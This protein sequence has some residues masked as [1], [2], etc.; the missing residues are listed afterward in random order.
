MTSADATQNPGRAVHP[1]WLPVAKI[2]GD[3]DWVGYTGGDGS[4]GE[5]LTCLL[6]HRAAP[7]IG[8]PQLTHR[9]RISVSFPEPFAPQG[10]T[11]AQWKQID[12]VINSAER[13]IVQRKLGLLV[14]MVVQPQR[15]EVLFYCHDPTQTLAALEAARDRAAAGLTVHA[16]VLEDPRWDA[17]H[18]IWAKHGVPD[19]V[20]GP[21]APPIVKELPPRHPAM[22]SEDAL[23]KWVRHHPPRC[24]AGLRLTWI[25]RPEPI[26]RMTVGFR[27]AHKT[28]GEVGRVHAHRLAETTPTSDAPVDGHGSLVSPI[29][30]TWKKGSEPEQIFDAAADGYQGEFK[31]SSQP[32]G[33]GVGPPVTCAKCGR[34]WF[35][36]AA[37]FGYHDA[38]FDL[39]RDQ[40][41]VEIQNYYA[42][43]RFQCTCTGCGEVI[44][45]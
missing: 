40:P 36:V 22:A 3:S 18:T 35:R 37:L 44:E 30:V 29:H 21:A 16:S 34:E 19:V 25:M 10:P 6:H 39:G 26:S 24:I 31:W 8:H 28:A 5:P 32:R 27:L 23:K 4:A 14:L 7:I 2:A 45:I 15:C 11:D 13:R 12:Q 1:D 42:I 43:A 41:G 20:V 38:A 17:F 33:D 9:A